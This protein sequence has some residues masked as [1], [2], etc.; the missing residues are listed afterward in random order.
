MMSYWRKRKNCRTED[1]VYTI[2]NNGQYDNHSIAYC[3]L[4]YYCAY[5]RY[6]YPAEF[7]TAC[8][9]NAANN[10][11]IE[12][13][14][15]LAK[16]RGFQLVQPTFRYS[17]AQYFFNKE[18]NSIYKG[19]AAIK[20]MNAQV[21]DELYEMRDMQ[22]DNFID[23]LVKSK[24]QTIIKTNQTE[25]LIQIEYFKEFG[26][27]P[28]LM[29]CLEVFKQ[30]GKR[31]EIKKAELE[32]LGV[33]EEFMQTISAKITAKKFTRVNMTAM[34]DKLVKIH[35]HPRPVMI[36]ELVAYQKKHFGHIDMKD[37][38][39]KRLAYIESV[40]TR[41]SPKLTTYA[42]SK[43][44]RLQCKVSKVAFCKQKIHDGDILVIKKCEQRNKQT[45]DENGKWV[46]LPNETE[47]W[48]TEYAVVDNIE[49][50]LEK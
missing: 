39:Y 3:L 8:L 18:T 44:E 17:K 28:Y 5:Y 47:W 33:D 16:E 2:G 26:E 13:G 29:K 20:G 38:K 19:V 50:Y 23:F 46:P 22:F 31:T 7:V 30:F 36:G 12:N 40:D 32:T 10:G 14:A 43:G 1:I 6:Y 25:A 35:Y 9:N 24:E 21:A 27:I 37:K 48:I 49:R 41:Y 34:M 45:K 4:G 42:L 15:L 11:D